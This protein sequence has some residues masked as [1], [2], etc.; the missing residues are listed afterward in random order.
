MKKIYS[1][2]IVVISMLFLFLS[3]NKE[4]SEITDTKDE[5]NIEDAIKG[6]WTCGDYFI[7][8]SSDN[9]CTAFIDYDFLESGNYIIKDKDIIIHNKFRNKEH[10]YQIVK[11]DDKSIKLK[12]TYEGRYVD[13]KDKTKVLTFYKSEEN[14]ENE[15]N[16]IIGRRFVYES[17]YFGVVT[18]SFNTSCLGV[19]TATKGTAKNYPLNILYVY[20]NN[21][22]YCIY[23]D[24][25]RDA[26]SIGAWNPYIGYVYRY[27]NLEFSNN[28]NIAGWSNKDIFD[29]NNLPR[30]Y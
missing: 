27:N 2:T 4:G 5:I 3:C 10:V 26:P 25:N 21:T 8:F 7:S 20:R 19:K 15:N 9:Y 22:L 28:G 1:Y 13:E 18:L 6:V 12:M 23:Y 30:E 29:E 14:P 11:I 24:T 16:P 17:T